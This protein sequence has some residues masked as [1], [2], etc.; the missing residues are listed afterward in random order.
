MFHYSS[1]QKLVLTQQ[2]LQT[3]YEKVKAE[4]SEK[5][6]KLQDLMSV[7]DKNLKR[8]VLSSDNKF[9]HNLESS[10][11]VLITQRQ[12]AENWS[13]FMP[14]SS[15]KVEITNCLKSEKEKY[16]NLAKSGGSQCTLSIFHIHTFHLHLFISLTLILVT[17]KCPSYI[18]IV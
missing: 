14:Y 4:E 17:H 5:S 11:P 15:G 18:I 6:N 8:S 1:N 10:C 9:R 7:D 3:D 12:K 16:N 13:K 2:Q